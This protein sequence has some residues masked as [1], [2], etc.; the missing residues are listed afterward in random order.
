MTEPQWF[1]DVNCL[2]MERKLQSPKEQSG[3]SIDTLD[4][5]LDDRGHGRERNIQTGALGDWGSSLGEGH[6]AYLACRKPLVP[7]PVFRKLGLVACA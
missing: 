1:Y 2:R 4:P 5:T 3:S 7:S 6:S